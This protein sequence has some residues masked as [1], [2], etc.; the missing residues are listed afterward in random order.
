MPS[1]ISEDED[2]KEDESTLPNEIDEGNKYDAYTAYLR[3][4]EKYFDEDEN[5]HGKFLAAEKAMQSRHHTK[6][7][8]V[9]ISQRI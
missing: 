3:G 6:V 5:E 1:E 8:S 4:D 7:T 9:N 2:R